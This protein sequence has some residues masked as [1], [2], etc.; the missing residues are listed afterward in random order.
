MCPIALFLY[1]QVLK[2]K[3]FKIIVFFLLV[4]FLLI[5]ETLICSWDVTRLDLEVGEAN[6]RLT[7]HKEENWVELEFSSVKD[8][9]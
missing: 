8:K 6:K 4:Y 1:V 2:S 7:F 3:Q 9:T 5:Y